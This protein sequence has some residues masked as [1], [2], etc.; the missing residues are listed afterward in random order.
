[1]L[2]ST[3]TV[4]IAVLL[5]LGLLPA[6]SIAEA[7]GPDAPGYWGA[8]NCYY[9]LAVQPVSPPGQ[10]RSQRWERQG[11]ATTDGRSVYFHND[12]DG[13]WQIRVH[14]IDG[15][16]AWQPLGNSP[17]ALETQAGHDQTTRRSCSHDVGC[18][19]TDEG[20]DRG[21]DKAMQLLRAHRHLG[22]NRTPTDQGGRR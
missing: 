7:Q 21:D 13:T 12:A 17:A 11:C 14:G 9:R 22:R 15:R 16:A 18:N 6:A 3:Q 4:Q 1:M 8:D 2:R 19:G 10:S 5:G 20:N